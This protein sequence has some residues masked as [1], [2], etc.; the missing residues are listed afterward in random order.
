M[1]RPGRAPSQGTELIDRLLARQP[2]EVNQALRQA[3]VG[4]AG[5]GGLGSVVAENLARAG[6]G[7]LVAADHDVV[8]PSNLNRQR[9][10]LDQVGLPKVQALGDNLG[11]S[12]PGLDY[13]PVRERVTASNCGRIFGSCQV[14]AECFDDPADKAELVVGLRRDLPGCAVVAASGLAGLG[15]GNTIRA[16]RISARLF[17]VGDTVSD[18]AHG[19]G[20]FAARVGIAAS[21]QSL[22]ILRILT[23]REP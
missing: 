3:S 16:Q 1:T 18:A 15:D 17:L 11:R 20:L 7:R 23:G 22:V 2:A 14:V 4:I 8:E 13:V 5:A 9:Y 21:M 10:T 12:C 6:V 19:E